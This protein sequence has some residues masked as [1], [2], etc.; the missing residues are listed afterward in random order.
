MKIAQYSYLFGEDASKSARLHDV[1]TETK[2]SR[3]RI[4]EMEGLSLM[5]NHEM[6]FH[7]MKLTVSEMLK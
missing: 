1:P 4:S 7:S 3:G 5:K 2:V 6:E